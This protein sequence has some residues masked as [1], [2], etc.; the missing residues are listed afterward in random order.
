MLAQFIVRT[1][2]SL[3]PNFRVL[4]A[5]SHN[6]FRIRTSKKCARNPFVIR[7]SK[8][9]DL[10]SFR[11]RTYEKRRGE[12]RN[13]LTRT[14]RIAVP[15][16]LP[17]QTHPDRSSANTRARTRLL[18]YTSPAPMANHS[19]ARQIPPSRCGVLR[20]GHLL[21]TSLLLYFLTLLLSELSAHPLHQGAV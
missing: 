19:A 14:C 3:F 7:T 2:R 5:N 18:R 4:P 1:S 15:S 17:G 13:M 11:I 8:T 9:K 12:G 10:K 6:P 20:R 21:V 16:C